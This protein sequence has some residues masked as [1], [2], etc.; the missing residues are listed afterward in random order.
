[1]N[2]SSIFPRFLYETYSP[3]GQGHRSYGENWR[4]VCAFLTC[5]KRPGSTEGAGLVWCWWLA[6]KGSLGTD[7]TSEDAL[8]EN[9]PSWWWVWEE[10]CNQRRLNVQRLWG[11]REPSES[12]EL[13]ACLGLSSEHQV[14][15]GARSSQNRDSNKDCLVGHI[16]FFSAVGSQWRM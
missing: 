12:E 9:C 15:V 8:T 10:I 3:C 1:M 11:R 4:K 16:Y 13:K 14:K 2:K 6:G 5:G 7:P